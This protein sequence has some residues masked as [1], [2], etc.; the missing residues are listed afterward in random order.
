M[1]DLDPVRFLLTFTN[2]RVDFPS[3]WTGNI[4]TV[5]IAPQKGEGHLPT[6]GC[7]KSPR[8]VYFL[9]FGNGFPCRFHGVSTAFPWRFHGSGR[10]G[11]HRQG[12]LGAFASMISILAEHRAILKAT[13]SWT[14][15]NGWSAMGFLDTVTRPGKHTKSYG[16][17]P[18][19]S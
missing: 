17:S 14:E 19:C 2:G 4:S 12:Y 9:A 3:G 8:N 15:S 11:S 6:V 10:V 18:S 7:R 16:K 13:V 1:V 5:I